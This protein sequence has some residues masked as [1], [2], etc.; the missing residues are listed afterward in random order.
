MD[1]R[2]VRLPSDD[3]ILISFSCASCVKPAEIER[4]VRTASLPVVLVTRGPGAQVPPA[5]W[6]PDFPAWLVVDE[7]AR[8]VPARFLDRAPQL[9]H[10]K[11]GRI[12]EV[13]GTHELAEDFLRRLK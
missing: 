7:K 5:L 4:A 1:A 6:K 12:Q 2:G 3:L 10:V 13:P 9:A 8:S 11:S